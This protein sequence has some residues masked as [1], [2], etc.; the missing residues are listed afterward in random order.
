MVE[1]IEFGMMVLEKLPGRNFSISQF[2]AQFQTGI[3]VFSIQ[4]IVFEFVTQLKLNFCYLL[5][6][7]MWFYPLPP[8]ASSSTTN[9]AASF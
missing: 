2:D 4:I 8:A 6:Y 5:A 3:K 7:C 1:T 9:R